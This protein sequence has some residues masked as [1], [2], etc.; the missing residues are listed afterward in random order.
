MNDAAP[1]QVLGAGGRELRFTNATSLQ[2]IEALPDLM[3]SERRNESQRIKDLHASHG[4]KLALL[5][6]NEETE[7]TAQQ[8]IYL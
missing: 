1:S 6:S 2:P 4:P 7:S 3:P 8:E 5:R